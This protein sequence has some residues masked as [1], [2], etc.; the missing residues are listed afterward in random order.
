MRTVIYDIETMRNFFSYT[1]I[2][3]D[4]ETPVVFTIS[5]W[6]N[7]AEKLVEYL[8][9]PMTMVGFNN[10]GF[11]AVVL[12][13]IVD[14]LDR[15]KE[16][17]G[18]NVAYSIYIF[19]QQFITK[20]D[21]EKPR[22]KMKNQLDLYLIN[23]YNNKARRTSLKS[24]QVAMGWYNVQEMPISHEEEITEDQVESV[25]SYNL[26]DV[27]STRK[28]YFLCS[29]KI[30]FR[31]AFSK[32]YKANF[33][34]RPDVSIGEEIFLRYIK[35]ASGLDKKDLKERV[36]YDVAVYLED[37]V[38]PY[39]KF[40]NKEFKYLLDSI[41]RTVVTEDTKFKHTVIFK[42]FHFHYGVGGIHGCIPAG[43]YEADDEHEIIDFDVKSYY[44]NIAITNNF[45]PKHIPQEVFINTYKRIFDDRVEAQKAG[46]DVVQA[47][48]KLALNGIFG[49]TG[50]STSAFFDRYY[51]YRITVNGQL[52]L[53]M[54]AEAYM[55]NVKNVQLLQIN[56]DG[57]TV[58]VHKSSIARI[59]EINQRF[60]KL[61]GLIL[62]DSKYKQMVIRDVNN[63]LAESIEGKV[64]KKG[65][66][67]TEKDWH[68]DNSYLIVP[69]ALEK[70]FVSKIPIKNTIFDARNIYDF[71]GR[72]KATRGWHAEVHTVEEGK[73]VIKNLGKVMRF[74]PTTTGDSVFKQNVDGRLNSLLAGGFARECNYFEEKENWEDYQIDYHFFGIECKKIIDEIEPQQLTLF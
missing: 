39:I 23:H 21:N 2:E 5:P 65:I 20:E 37:C 43:K 71:F 31:R 51:F 32:M 12:D 22:T 3:E 24:L 30:E 6:N 57:L 28:F 25:L 53:T 19:V 47:G 10:V 11:D 1:D 7:D 29:E 66:F 49:K 27:L 62:E 61:T 58:R 8:D 52:L 4:S 70:Y 55:T 56:T 60:M 44:P 9:Q 69:K 63:Y 64:K 13:H 42:G 14:N 38:I 18:H 68:K 48:L 36:R 67:E 40:Q 33:L 46:D 72:Y 45:H 17:P 15:Y 59:E 74:L 41:K 16:M 26:N 34:N 73:K 54:L 35:A 50:E